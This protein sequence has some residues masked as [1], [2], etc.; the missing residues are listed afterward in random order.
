M[1]DIL[2][3]TIT[4]KHFLTTAGSLII[5]VAAATSLYWQVEMNAR[6]QSK[7]YTAIA[8]KLEKIEKSIESCRESHMSFDRRIEELE[9]NHKN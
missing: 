6:E 4:V 5:A 1:G 3:S 7:A 8:T 9:K 2:N